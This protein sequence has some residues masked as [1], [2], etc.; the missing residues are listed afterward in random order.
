MPRSFADSV[1]FLLEL[2][3][4][5]T[6]LQ[7]TIPPAGPPCTRCQ[8]RENYSIDLLCRGCHRA[9]VRVSRLH[10]CHITAFVLVCF[11]AIQY[12]DLLTPLPFSQV[13]FVWFLL[14]LSSYFSSF[15]FKG[16]FIYANLIVWL[17]F[18]VTAIPLLADIDVRVTQYFA[19]QAAQ[20]A[21]IAGLRLVGLV[22]IVGTILLWG[23][24]EGT[25]RLSEQNDLS[26]LVPFLIVIPVNVGLVSAL[27]D[28]L[29]VEVVSTSF[30]KPITEAIDHL[31]GPEILQRLAA[32][33]WFFT[34]SAY[35]RF[36]IVTVYLTVLV[37]T[38][39]VME[40][41]KH[42]VA[43]G[44]F[45]YGARKLALAI[46]YSARAVRPT[47]QIWWAVT[48]HSLMR[49]TPALLYP[50]ILFLFYELIDGPELPLNQKGVVVTLVHIGLLLVMV[51]FF[52]HV[53][54]DF[55]L[56]GFY[57]ITFANATKAHFN[58]LLWIIFS[59]LVASLWFNG[60][61]LDYAKAVG[62]T[63]IG[64]GFVVLAAVWIHDKI[65]GNI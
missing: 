64:L 49:F 31:W 34:V 13:L 65:T 11:L 9:P 3:Q 6:S 16:H 52:I 4:L 25:R 27:L 26:W 61:A 63:L 1:S 62:G 2:P 10:W 38:L 19:G 35:V 46:K 41:I 39:G 56:S 42:G 59:I 12:P 58:V 22:I 15:V 33:G 48:H 5:V 8:Y 53:A 37:G 29:P 45:T 28:F 40:S 51:P 7:H 55:P 60:T 18:L 54:C 23:L 20:L 30:T 21:L 24:L 17:F 43:A 47:V 36:E 57:S 14:F 50:F 44:V 32:I